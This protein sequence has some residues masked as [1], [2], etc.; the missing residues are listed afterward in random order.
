MLD[1]K[2]TLKTVGANGQISLGKKYAGRHVLIEEQA[3]GVWLVRT[4]RV[5]PDDEAWIL[6]P[7][8]AADLQAALEHAVKTKVSTDNT[9]AILQ[10]LQHGAGGGRSTRC[11]GLVRGQACRQGAGDETVNLGAQAVPGPPHTHAEGRQRQPTGSQSHPAEG[12]AGHRRKDGRRAQRG[13][14]P[15]FGKAGRRCGV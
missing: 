2:I 4:A 11:G 5:I 15:C 3:E 7:K 9:D 10:R 12:G 14:A 8:A 13:Q 1:D 6:E